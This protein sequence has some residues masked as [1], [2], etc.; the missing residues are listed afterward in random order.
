[1]LLDRVNEGNVRPGNGMSK[2][3]ERK[4]EWRKENEKKMSGEELVHR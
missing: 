4:K 2:G 1:M 3:Q